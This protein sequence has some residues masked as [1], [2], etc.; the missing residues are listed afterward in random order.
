MSKQDRIKLTQYI[1]ACETNVAKKKFQEHLDDYKATCNKL[2]EIKTQKDVLILRKK[3]VVGAIIIG[4]SINHKNSINFTCYT[5]YNLLKEVKPEIVIVEEAAEVLE[6]QLLA[7]ISTWTQYMLLVGDHQQ[8]RPPVDSYHLRKD[9]SFD[10]SMMERL[11]N[12]NMSYGVL[13]KP[14]T[15]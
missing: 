4:A 1:I 8:L 3:K 6:P 2:N 10:V 15:P 9:Y 13:A 5:C 7:C 14:A 11:I 12:N